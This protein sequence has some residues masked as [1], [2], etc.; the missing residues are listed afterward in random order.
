[1]VQPQITRYNILMVYEPEGCQGIT[2]IPYHSPFFPYPEDMARL[3]YGN[4]L[5]LEYNIFLSRLSLPSA[6]RAQIRI[7]HIA[8]Y[9]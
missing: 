7:N 1:M 4:L 9:N 2:L 5:S 6:S 8:M 3:V